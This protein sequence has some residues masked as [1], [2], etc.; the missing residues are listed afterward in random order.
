MTDY[1]PVIGLEVHAQLLTRTKLFCGCSTN[2]GAPPNTNVCPVCLGLPGS[3]PVLNAEAVAMAVRAAIALGCSIEPTSIFARK[4]YFYPDL[5]KGYQI[6][7]YEEP[8]SRHG[9]LD[10]DL[11]GVQK[12]IGITRVHMEEDAGKNVHGVGGDSLVDLNRAGVPLVEIVG[13]PDLRSSSEAAAYLRA[14]RDVLVFIGVNDGNLEEGSF[15]CDANVS[16][17]PRGTT[18]FGTR[19]EIKNINSFRFV[20]RAIDAEI[21]RQTAILDAGGSITQETRSFDPDTGHTKTLRSKEDAHDY[22]YFP[23]PDLPPLA[24]EPAFVAAQ[25]SALPELPA[26][27]RKRFVDELKLPPAAALT[28][29][30]HP[31]YARFFAAACAGFG[32]PIKVANWVVNEVLRGAKSHGLEATFSVTPAQVAELLSLVE[33]GEISG[34]QAKEVYAELE[35]HADRAPRAVVEQRGMRV[36]SD[37]GAI[38]ALVEKVLAAHPEQVASVRAGKKGVLGFLVGQVMKESKGSANPKLVSSLVEKLTS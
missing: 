36:V 13:E 7:Q 8:F 4:N 1:E 37:E 22:R 25:K 9:S 16:L 34:K 10:V 29:T 35:G 11:D 27:M 15:R 23:E 6:S 19:C 30:G 38:R 31:G 17:R 12:R 32:D 24:L 3:L 18:K 28:L 20:Q 2:F 14:L 33:S 21:A 5:P 26:V